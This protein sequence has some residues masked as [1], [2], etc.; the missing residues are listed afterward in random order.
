VY[1]PGGSSEA[2]YQHRLY[3][4]HN[5]PQVSR[6]IDRL[7]DF[8]RAGLSLPDNV[9]NQQLA[10][11]DLVDVFRQ[12]ATEMFN[13]HLLLLEKAADEKNIGKFETEATILRKTLGQME[14][15]LSSRPDY[16]LEDLAKSLARADSGPKLDEA[17]AWL[18]DAGLTF[19]KAYPTITDYQ[20]KDIYELNRFYY[21]P[22]VEKYLELRLRSLR[23]GTEFPR[24]QMNADYRKIEMDWCQKGYDPKDA[25][26]YVGPMWKAV[27]DAFDRLTRQRNT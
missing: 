20:S 22:R 12:Y 2:R 3:P 25:P 6:R 26:P 9:K 24:G 15:V 19:A 13:Q 7:A 21:R 8:L 27:R 1:G 23:N 16:R 5:L 14:L 4:K 18:R 10:G 17:K 11:N